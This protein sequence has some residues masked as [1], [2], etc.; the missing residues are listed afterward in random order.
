MAKDKY[1]SINSDVTGYSFAN[2]GLFTGFASGVY[3]AVYSLVILGI[4]TGILGDEKLASSVVGI[5]VAL[6]SV[7]CMMVGL[8]SKELKEYL[9]EEDFALFENMLRAPQH[10]RTFVQMNA[11]S[12]VIAPVLKEELKNDKNVRKDIDYDYYAYLLSLTEVIPV[13]YAARHG[14]GTGEA[15]R[16]GFEYMRS[17][18]ESIT[19]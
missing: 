5:Y 11:A 10:I 4:F 3:N 8:F 18:Y 15:V 12:E 9:S 7:F 1:I 17:I 2:L 16:L 19:K 13:D 14:L 6:Y